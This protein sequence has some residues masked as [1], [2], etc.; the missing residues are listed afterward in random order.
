M[1]DESART[2]F[3]QYPSAQAYNKLYQ[4]PPPYNNPTVKGYTL[5][6]LAGLVTTLPLVPYVLWRNA[7]FGS[8]RALKELGD[9]EPRYDPTVIPVS[10]GHSSYPL[11]YTK[12]DPSALRTLPNNTPGRF[13][14]IADYHEAYRSGRLTPRDV[15][16]FLLPLIRRD[17]GKHTPYTAAFVDS[18]VEL[19]MA[20]ADASTRRWQ[21]GKPLGVLDGIPFSAKDEVDV[22]GYKRY[23]GTT[24]DYTGG[25]EVETSWCVKKVEE[26]GGIMMGKNN[27]H[28][29]GMDTNGNNPNWG[30]PL[31]PYNSQYYPGGS[32]SGGASAV[33]S[34]LVPFAIGSDGGGSIRIPSNY[35]GLYGLKT[36]HGRVSV[37]PLPRSGNTV[38]INGPIASNMSDLEIY[39][40]VLAQPDPSNLT[41]RCFAPPKPVTAPRKKVLG[42]CKPWFDR[43]VPAVQEACQSALQYMTTELGY[44]IVDI[45]IPYLHEG[46]I[47]HALT[48]LS[49]VLAEQPDLSILTA[50]NRVL[51]K[52]AQSSTAHDFIIAQKVRHAVMQHL[53]HLF[54]KY[55]GLVIVTPTTPNAGWPIGDGEATFGVTDG[56]MQVFNMEYVWMANFTGV[57]CIQFPVGY[58]DGV[59][60]TGKVPVGMMGHG[61]WGSEDSLIEFGFDGE[62]WLNKG[63]NGGKLR[64]EAWVDVLEGSEKGRAV[65]NSFQ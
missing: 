22:K 10:S 18:N 64:P 23:V 31:N 20:A 34:G 61:D 52:V 2:T 26:E 16:E 13:Y 5:H 63:Y 43:A 54:Q 59:K 21:E 7:G 12:P 24:K 53:A 8:L 4:A 37:S 11:E 58:V 3:L 29:M 25:K 19:I 9:V 36:S 40:R 39:Y 57:P 41:S 32:T 42:I 30:T 15:V 60:G 44:T 51:L 48:I 65:E 56:N 27:M 47:A 46:Q 38:V 14:T 49:E 1:S 6:Y 45:D 33:G 35:C 55:P 28:E 50:P 17:V 62:A